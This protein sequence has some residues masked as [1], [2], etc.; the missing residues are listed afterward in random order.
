MAEN[1]DPLTKVGLFTLGWTGIKLFC[2]DA[3]G[4]VLGLAS[5][6]LFGG[7]IQGAVASAAAA[8]FGS[9]VAFGMAKLETPVRKKALELLDEY[10]SL[11]GI[12]KVV[13]RDGLKAVLTLRLAPI[14]P[15]PIGLYNYVY[16]V[17]NVPFFDFAGGI[18]LGSLKPYFL[19]SYLGIFG[20]E[21]VEG[22]SDGGGL[23]DI[24]LLTTLAVSVLIGV[25]ASQ[26][27]GETWDSVLEEV[28][29][30]KK[31]KMAAMEDDEEV[32]DGLKR[33]FLG[34]ELPQW[35]VDFQKSLKEADNIVEDLIAVE[36]SA[37][38]W[39][40]TKQEGGPPA[41]LDPALKPGSPELEEV[42]EGLKLGQSFCIGLVLS[43]QLFAAFTKFADPLYDETTD[44]F[45]QERISTSTVQ[46]VDQEAVQ[47]Q[48]DELLSKL[49][50]LRAE[51]EAKL[52][53]VNR[54][55][56]DL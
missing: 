40:Y 30:E 48:T 33:E 54:E 35:A 24:L 8:T 46:Q 25:F 18:F 19:D 42:N 16:G 32:D 3:G 13:A 31:A 29:A 41:N 44:D 15:I 36:Y 50:E 17:T 4:V 20:K 43:P 26:L 9:S 2:F 12:E 56:E 23:Q 34:F 14:L 5:G 11:R 37:K 53:K 6:I 55:L 1:M 49:E 7:V 21:M 47:S 39:N 38:V 28:E 10:P 51:A 45:V 52:S 27:A 22:T